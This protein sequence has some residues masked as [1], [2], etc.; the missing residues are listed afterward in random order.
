MIRRHPRP[1][2]TAIARAHR[3]VAAPFGRMAVHRMLRHGLPTR[4]AKP[5]LYL[6]TGS[7]PDDV[8]AVADRIERRRGEIAQSAEVYQFRYHDGGIGAARWAERADDTYAAPVLTS[9]YF[10]VT[11][12][13]SKRWGIFLHLCADAF[14]ARVILELGTCVGISG[15]YLATT[16]SAPE[17][18]TLEGSHAIAAVAETTFTAVSARAAVVRGR[19]EETLQQTL[20]NLASEGRAVDV[21][22]IDGHHD[23]AAT[24]HYVRTLLPFLADEALII[25]DDIHLHADMWRAWQA[26][27]R[28]DG[29]AAAVNVGRL[30][31]LVYDRS[32]AGVREFDLSRYTG[33]WR[34]RGSRADTMAPR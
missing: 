33:W 10:A 16:V 26:V 9:E 13:I 20:A 11:S 2:R 31:L 23:E 29:V 34:V 4:L 14:H 24:L 19:F 21:A 28:F 6:F 25:L 22:Y 12:S 18:I 32:A 1:V 7:V 15:A 17:L 27:C 5:L 30:G 8:A 3:F